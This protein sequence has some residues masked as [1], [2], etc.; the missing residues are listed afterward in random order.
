MPPG[1]DN[2]LKF[3]RV[4]QYKLAAIICKGLNE[5][6]CV[7]RKPKMILR[8]P[9]YAM[10]EDGNLVGWIGCSRRYG[11][12]YEVRHLTVLP[13]ARGRGLGQAALKHILYLLAQRGVVYCYAHIRQDNIASQELFEKMGFKLMRDGPIRKYTLSLTRGRL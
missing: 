12:V 3:V 1:G 10:F 5:H 2:L 11:A 8:N 6:N 4:R 9:H 13:E 7:E